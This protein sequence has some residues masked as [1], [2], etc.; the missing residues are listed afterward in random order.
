MNINSVNYDSYLAAI[1]QAQTINTQQTYVQTSKTEKDSYIP[2][3]TSTDTAIPSGIYGANGIGLETFSP[4]TNVNTD[5]EMSADQGTNVSAGS[6]GVGGGSSDSEEATETEVV[7]I[8][9]ITYLQ[10]TTTDENG[11]ITVTRTL[12][13]ASPVNNEKSVNTIDQNMQESNKL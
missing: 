13:G 6:G 11:N 8:D 1:A 3:M 12:L 7:T 10:T 2:S 4:V 9:G 5:S